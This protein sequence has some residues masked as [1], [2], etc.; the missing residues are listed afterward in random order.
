MNKI[1]VPITFNAYKH[2]FRFLKWQINKWKQQ[3]W[4]AVEKELHTLGENLLDFYIGE[5]QVI[6]ICEEVSG[7]FK[8]EKIFDF[9][10]FR[11]WLGNAEYRKIELSDHSQW[12]IKK[13]INP[14]RYIHIHPAKY[15]LHTLRI[16]AVT[17]KTVC[18]LQIRSIV[19]QESMKVNLQQ[20]N[21]IRKEF[22]HLSPIK[23]LSYNEGIFKVWRMFEEYKTA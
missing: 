3:E 18:A 22:L 1:P 7:Y 23:S 8:H 2:H 9:E 15:D 20:V 21:N 14:Q 17:L 11:I 5:L 19:I 4:R 10:A 12:V 16:R 13:S 6:T